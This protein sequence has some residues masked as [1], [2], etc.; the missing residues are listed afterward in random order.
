MPSIAPSTRTARRLPAAALAALLAAVA[1]AGSEDPSPPPPGEQEELPAARIEDLPPGITLT[2]SGAIRYQPDG[3]AEIDGPFTIT[4]QGV[5]FQADRAVLRE[6]RYLEA[7]GNVLVTWGPNRLS[8]SRVTYDL[9]AREGTVE[10]AEGVIDPDYQFRAAEARKVGEDLV[11]LTDAEITT[12]T[13]PVPY[14]S[15]RISTARVRVNGYARMWNSRL[16]VRGVPVLYLPFLFWPVKDGRAPGLLMPSL[17]STQNRG[18]VFTQPVFIPIGRSVDVTLAAHWY[19]EAGLGIGTELRAVPNRDGRIAFGGFYID[20]QVSD[21]SRYRYTYQQTQ[22]FSNGFRMVA[23]LNFVSDFD[24]FTDYERE[25]DLTSTPNIL[26]R[27]EF[28]R[29]GKWTSINVREL[30][31]EQLFSDGTSLV[32]QTLPEI[33]WRGRTRRLGETP[34]YL[35]YES[36]LASI[37]QRG[38]LQGDPIDADY[39]RGDVFPSLSLPVTPAPWLDVNFDA[40]YRVTYYTQQQRFIPGFV[41]PV[42]EVV[43]DALYRG[44]GAVGVELTG[45]KLYRVYE[46][47]GSSYSSRYKHSF[48]PTVRYR[49][50][51]GFEDAEHV[52]VFDE[53]DRYGIAGNSI[54]Y[55]LRSRLFAKR[56]RMVPAASPDAGERILMPGAS[57]SEPL[58]G[59]PA[60]DETGETVAATV[61]A[62]EVKDEPVEIATVE[63][64]QLR[65]FDTD[66]S[67]AD[68]DLDG[69][70]ESLSPYSEVVLNGRYSP[71]PR[72]SL[73]VRAAWHVLYREVSGATLSGGL[74]GNR[75]RLRSSLVYRNGLGAVA[76]TVEGAEGELETVYVERDNNTQLNLAAGVFLFGGRMAVDINATF[77][78]DP[79]SGQSHIPNRQ[80]RVQYRTQCCTFLLERLAR[81]FSDIQNRS[82]YYLRVDLRGVGKILDQKF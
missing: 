26:A 14:W 30:R 37:Q 59:F 66:L 78:A 79:P 51:E 12:C 25:L 73:D 57:E 45:P 60:A 82:D 20:D 15:F 65:S 16:R 44:V 56:P 80:W 18:T 13:Q 68:L 17:G 81:N 46:T 48:E 71:T 28:S 43:D 11:Y 41:G 40:S 64:S 2:F 23:D 21:A 22:A 74:S 50:S 67:A 63:V 7:E 75:G 3:A 70:L 36:S 31:N 72:T 5:R 58:P 4:H 54:G 6:R 77:D 61:A 38:V 42:R 27:L 55:G 19:T 29:P 33:E 76:Q 32:Q 39:L 8:G 34:V 35:A 52:L 53:V 24:F 62:E 69:T 1:L 9:E 47:P 49:Y 10:N